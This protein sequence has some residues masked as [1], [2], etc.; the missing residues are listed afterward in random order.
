M[1]VSPE[2]AESSTGQPVGSGAEPTGGREASGGSDVSARAGQFARGA[3]LGAVASTLQAQREEVLD[4]WLRAAAEQ[5]FHQGRLPEAV[6][7]HIPALFDAIVDLLRRSAPRSRDARPPLND[8]AVLAAAQSHAA[9]RFAQGLTPTEVATEFRLLRQEIWWTLRKHLDDAT[10]TSDVLAA[11]LLINDGL[12]GAIATALAS[13]GAHEAER[14]RLAAELATQ[15]AQLAAIVE[16]SEDAILSK[17]LDGIITSW[18]RAAERLY[19]YTAAEVIGR[20][21]ALLVPP[22][23]PDEL[24]TI[25]TRLRRGERLESYETVRV[26]K[27]GTR[28]DVSVT[29]SPVRDASGVIVG[30]SAIARDIT[31]RKALEQEREMFL[32]AVTHDLKNPLAVI[33]GTAQ[34]LQRQLTRGPIAQEALLARLQSIDAAAQRLETQLNDLQD[35]AHLREGRP[36]ALNRRP[37]DLVLLVQQVAAQRQAATT[38][39]EIVVAPT[40]S[41]LVGNWDRARLER[42]V[43]NLLTNAVKFSPRGG[44]ITLSISHDGDSAVLRVQDEGIGIPAADL[45]YVFE[46]FR[47][48]SNVSGSIAGS[49]IGLATARQIAQQHGGSLSAESQEGQ[50]STFTLRLPL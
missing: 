10:P 50:G 28:L 31:E 46:W 6:A 34:T 24:A 15:R 47:R 20:S 13:L 41:E 36:L 32:A 19:G 11:E 29:I 8:P 43:D 33:R 5:P 16:S 42:V 2:N 22:D 25:L 26:C 38:E 27:D 12:D 23:R 1:T 49:G 17:T 21:V 4:R 7:D 48:G 3:D 45:P 39:H 18:N 14:Q 40:V 35:V 44:R 37:T 9:I 30:A